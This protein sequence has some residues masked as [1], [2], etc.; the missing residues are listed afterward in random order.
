MSQ[1]SELE[2]LVA[3]RHT[4]DLAEH[5]E[6]V[7]RGGEG[8]FFSRAAIILYENPDRQEVWARFVQQLTRIYGVNWRG[9]EALNVQRSLTCNQRGC[10]ELALNGLCDRCLTKAL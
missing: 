7:L 4:L 3:G 2:M 10:T 8:A 6:R 1:I 5:G 9:W